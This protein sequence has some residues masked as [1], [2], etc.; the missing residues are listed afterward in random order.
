MRIKHGGIIGTLQT[1]PFYEFQYHLVPLIQYSAIAKTILVRSL[2][3]HIF[4]RAENQPL[5]QRLKQKRRT[6]FKNLQNVFAQLQEHFWFIQIY[7]FLFNYN[8]QNKKSCYI[9]ANEE[10][11]CKFVK[12]MRRFFLIVFLKVYFPRG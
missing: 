1:I 9:F 2:S 8:T 12:T 7:N 5:K 6:I 3:F 10:M 4:T 11:F